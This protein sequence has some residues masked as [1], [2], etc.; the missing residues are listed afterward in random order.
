LTVYTTFQ[1]PL[2]QQRDEK[3][4]KFKTQHAQ[5]GEPPVNRDT[6]ISD[7]IFGD[8]RDV[9]QEVVDEMEK[10]RFAWGIR[11][12]LFGPNSAAP[13]PQQSTPQANPAQGPTGSEPPETP[14]TTG[15]SK[16]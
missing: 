8:L 2:Q 15:S 7:A 6:A 1:P 12:A 4:G 14:A 3:E 16:T 10:R 9:K 5:D 13:S 11:R